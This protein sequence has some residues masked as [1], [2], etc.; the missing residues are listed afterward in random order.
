[1]LKNY[2]E[3]IIASFS[4]HNVNINLVINDVVNGLR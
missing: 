1:M 3:T 4:Q 2:F